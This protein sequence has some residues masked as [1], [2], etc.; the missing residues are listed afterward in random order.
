MRENKMKKTIAIGL[1]VAL[2]SMVSA[3]SPF[4][5][6][7]FNDADGA[8]S[9]VNSGTAGKKWTQGDTGSLIDTAFSPNNTAGFVGSVSGGNAFSISQKVVEFPKAKSFT[10]GGWICRTAEMAAVNANIFGNAARGAGFSINMTAAGLYRLSIAPAGGQ[11][12]FAHPNGR[13]K[14]ELNTW[15][16]IA[17]TYDGTKSQ[18]NV[19]YYSATDTTA[20]K[21]GATVSL[22]MGDVPAGVIPLVLGGNPTS[23]VT[24]LYD[25][26]RIYISETDATGVL[27]PSEIKEWMQNSD[28]GSGS[29]PEKTIIVGKA[30]TPSFVSTGHHRKI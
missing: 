15:T 5:T 30:C 4:V 6:L 10:I 20:L 23:F 16:F 14:L 24:G 13:S 18:D 19:T 3:R 8:S 12:G 27:S 1:V 9:L 28:V 7:N 25:D 11:D 22:N 29:A 21:A 26:L 2:A 17:I